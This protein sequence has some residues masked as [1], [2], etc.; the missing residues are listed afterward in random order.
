MKINLMK[1]W[2]KKRLKF[3]LMMAEKLELYISDIK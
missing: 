1:T 2:L 3:Y